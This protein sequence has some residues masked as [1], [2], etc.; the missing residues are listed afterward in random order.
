VADQVK[1]QLPIADDPEIRAYVNDIGQQLA[2]LTG[3]MS[4]T[5]ALK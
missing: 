1:R 3:G 4:S 2:A 5:T